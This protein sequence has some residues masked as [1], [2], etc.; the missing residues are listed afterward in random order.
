MA[1]ALTA[2]LKL[3]LPEIGASKD[4]WGTKLNEN[5]IVLDRILGLTAPN[6]LFLPRAGGNITN[7]LRVG[8]NAHFDFMAGDSAFSAALLR[9]TDNA[10]AYTF[11]G[12]D[13][14][15]G[16][17][18]ALD[19]VLNARM[20]DA[21]YLRPGAS[22]SLTGGT[23]ADLL[24]GHAAS[25][26]AVRRVSDGAETHAI[27]DDDI[28]T[29]DIPSQANSLINR[30]MGDKRYARRD[31]G[32]TFTF[33]QFIDADFRV[34]GNDAAIVRMAEGANSP[35]FVTRKS[36]GFVTH[37]IHPGDISDPDTASSIR[38]ILTA[39]MADNRYI[40]ANDA[41]VAKKNIDNSFTTGQTVRNSVAVQA[42]GGG[43]ARYQ[44]YDASGRLGGEFIR[45]PSGNLLYMRAVVFGT[46]SYKDMVLDASSGVVTAAA[47]AGDGSRLTNLQA[48]DI[49]GTL[50]DARIPANIVRN[51]RE[52]VAGNGLTGGGA[53]N[54]DRTISLGA[55]SA[56][57]YTS[58]NSVTATSHTHELGEA[59]VRQLIADGTA[60]AVGTYAMLR[61]VNGGYFRPGDVAPGSSLVH[62]SAGGLETHPSMPNPGPHYA[63]GTWR[64]MGMSTSYAGNNLQNAAY[65]TTLWMR[66]S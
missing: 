33:A 21:R 54:A 38:S 62:A 20:G 45:P 3:K 23:L 7:S 17:V 31:V 28:T 27:L 48:G 57:T 47:F 56:I 11:Y 43:D 37:Q 26:F 61:A 32:N 46:T 22:V 25:T 66:I 58:Q 9:K 60:G 64:C 6:G 13:A 8:G 55:P 36:D 39:A 19:A 5:F 65:N 42:S 59:S 52:I 53:L 4:T 24:L 51:S 30:A 2:N 34:R 12:D 1:D 18:G 14:L 10:R 40:R 41:N 16:T 44:L 35:F 15:D 63:S 50:A 49:A 29:P